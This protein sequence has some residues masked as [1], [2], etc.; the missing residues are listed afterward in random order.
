MAPSE[1]HLQLVVTW[2]CNL[3]CNFLA[4]IC[5]CSRWKYIS[6]CCP[7]KKI[8]GCLSGI[9]LKCICAL[10]RSNKT[11][12]IVL[13]VPAIWYT[14]LCGCLTF[15]S[16]SHTFSLACDVFLTLFCLLKT[17]FVQERLWFQQFRG[18]W[19]QCFQA[20]RTEGKQLSDR[21]LREQR[22]CVWVC[23]WFRNHD[24][25]LDLLISLDE[26]RDQIVT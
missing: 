16:H 12:N 5:L 7:D 14:L 10:K 8:A 6:V 21:Q 17:A 24:G 2:K 18:W 9:T 19:E 3:D 15:M 26:A 23:S 4:L 1:A 13:S 22:E 25:F 11:K 20:G